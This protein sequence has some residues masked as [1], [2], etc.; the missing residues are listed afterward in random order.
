M[1]F[2]NCCINSTAIWINRQEIFQEKKYK[3]L[4]VT[5]CALYL[6]VEKKYYFEMLCI[7]FSTQRYRD[8]ELHR[9]L[10]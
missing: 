4:C 2:K 9:G 5:R 7:L 6:C 10:L 8:W 3:I 1:V